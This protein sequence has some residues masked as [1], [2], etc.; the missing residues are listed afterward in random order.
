MPRSDQQG[1]PPTAPSLPL[2]H[3]N[4]PSRHVK[5]QR[6]KGGTERERRGP[7]TP[8]SLPLMLIAIHGATS[9]CLPLDIH[10]EGRSGREGVALQAGPPDDAPLR[11]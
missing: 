6:E 8:T 1:L 9:T 2:S 5:D 10:I 11:L 4:M 7:N 3:H